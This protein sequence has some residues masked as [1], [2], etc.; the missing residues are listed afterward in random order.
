MRASKSLRIE[1]K[2]SIIEGYDADLT[3]VDLE[4]HRIISDE[5]TWT[6]VDGP[7]MRKGCDGWPNTPS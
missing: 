2:G 7:P 6:K 5:N 3:L 4:T 1:K